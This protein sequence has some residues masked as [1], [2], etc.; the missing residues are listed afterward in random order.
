MPTDRDNRLMRRF[1]PFFITGLVFLAAAGGG[2]FLFR[3]KTAITPLKIAEGKPGA[4]PAHVRGSNSAQVTLEEFGDYQCAPCGVLAGTLLRIEHKFGPRIRLVFRQFPLTMHP[5]GM[6]A[7]TAAE[8]AGLQGHF[9]EMHDLLF[10]NAL[11]WGKESP[12]PRRPV[13]AS[14]PNL[15]EDES[16]GVVRDT[17]LGYATKIGLDQERFKKDMESEEVK[18]RIAADQER[19]VSMGVDRTPILLIDGV[20]IPFASLKYE[21]LQGLIDDALNGKPPAPETPSP[22]PSPA[23]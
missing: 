23:Q 6:T 13:G 19:G 5:H 3:A 11:T 10:Q 2:I 12:R 1:I 9:W 8:A 20:K 14:A 17:F 16:G 4:E 22:T 7:A 21:T 18:A 15:V